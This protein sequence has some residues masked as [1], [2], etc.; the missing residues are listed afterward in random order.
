MCSAE[1]LSRGSGLYIG[2]HCSR[3][4]AGQAHKTAVRK[5]PQPRVRSPPDATILARL[6]RI[7]LR[8]VEIVSWPGHN[9][10]C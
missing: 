3:S 1:P 7:L 6:L 5:D 8:E 2:L 9:L 4:P 10:Q